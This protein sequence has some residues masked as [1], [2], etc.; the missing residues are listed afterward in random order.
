MAVV[1]ANGEPSDD[2]Q[3]DLAGRL[4]ESVFPLLASLVPKV[5]LE[6][7]TQALAP[8]LEALAAAAEAA[9]ASFVGQIEPPVLSPGL[10]AALERVRE[11]L[12]VNWPAG[13]EIEDVT[14]VI[15]DD[16]I[17]L[18]WVPPAAVV[19]EVLDAPDRGARVSVLLSHT[20]ELLRDCRRV[21]AD[22][23]ADRLQ[24]QLPLAPR[25]LDA[26]E[27]GHHEAAQ[28]LAVVVTDATIAGWIIGKFEKLEKQ[29]HF[30][31]EETPFDEWRLKAAVAPL[32]NFKQRYF[33][34]QGTRPTGLNRQV[35]VHYAEADHFTKG[36]ALIAC[37]LMTSVL[38]AFQDFEENT[39]DRP[40]A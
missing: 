24:R 21:L 14:A 40:Q 27:Q 2:W 13:I 20:D 33:A 30:D 3:Q 38:R 22:V 11:Q 19:D 36:N 1:G 32:R 29:V 17:P 26:I 35:T 16:G 6:K 4:A 8:G 31:P 34:G 18:V 28:A 10:L 7:V 25:A 39:A 23:N 5:D 9:A 37:L 12:P 15:Q